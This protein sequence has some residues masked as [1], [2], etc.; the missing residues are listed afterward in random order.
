MAQTDR[1]LSITHLNRGSNQRFSCNAGY[2]EVGRCY[3]KSELEDC[4]GDKANKWG[5]HL[6]FETQGRHDQKSKNRATSGPTKSTYMYLLRK[7]KK[8]F[9]NNMKAIGPDVFKKIN[10][11]RNN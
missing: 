1:T 6:G 11:H 10:T 9:N 3:T 4:V 8:K 2:Q 7:L 5:I